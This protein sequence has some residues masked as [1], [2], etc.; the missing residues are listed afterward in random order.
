MALEVFKLIQ[1]KYT[2][3]NSSSER[4]QRN[5]VRASLEQMLSEQLTGSDDVLEFEVTKQ[6]MLNDIIA[7][8]DEAP[9]VDKYVIM[10]SPDT[11]TIFTAREKEIEGWV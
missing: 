3:D 11:I 7:V 1:K 2:K 8:I 6:N 9:L 4:L 5:K 10:Q